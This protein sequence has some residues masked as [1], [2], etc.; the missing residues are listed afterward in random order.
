MTGR[1]GGQRVIRKAKDSIETF[2]VTVR[3]ITRMALVVG[4]V[5]LAAH[6]LQRYPWHHFTAA[7]V[8]GVIM[9][10]YGAVGL[11]R[12]VADRRRV[13]QWIAI[14]DIDEAEA[15]MEVARQSARRLPPWHQAQ[16]DSRKREV[17]RDLKA[18]P[19]Q[20]LRSR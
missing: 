12:E 13:K 20:T 14:E 2:L 15:D 1:P 9:A 6:M 10:G 17:V 18:R 7:W 3:P 19:P 5:W 8:T 11:Y 4:G 16:F